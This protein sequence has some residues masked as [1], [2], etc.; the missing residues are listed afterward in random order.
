M[1]EKCVCHLNGYQLKDAVAR[2]MVENT[3]A[4]VALL[5]DRK[6]LFI[7]DSYATGTG[8]GFENVS[9]P[10]VVR[11]ILRLTEGVNYFRYAI[12]GAGFATTTSPYNFVNQAELACAAMDESTRA[13][14][15]DIVVGGGANDAHSTDDALYNGI[16]NFVSY[17]RSYFPNAKIHLFGLGWE[18]HSDFRTRLMNTYYVYERASNNGYAYHSLYPIL[19]NDEYISAD[20]CHP[21]DSGYYAL[22]MAVAN[23]LMGGY[24][25]KLLAPSGLNICG[26]YHNVYTDGV[27]V[28]INWKQGT[29]AHAAS[30]TGD[31]TRFSDAS[32]YQLLGCDIVG[33]FSFMKDVI[34]TMTDESVTYARVR[35]S[36]V[37]EGD[38][39]IGLYA[40]SISIV[41][42]AWT[43]YPNIAKISFAEETTVIP[44]WKA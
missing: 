17:C 32:C 35:L 16:A 26:V 20:G 25:E 43:N 9:W 36:F 33:E 6:F 31:F 3:A 28:Y 7:G 37:R 1:E 18:V 11:D 2:N 34:L 23:C 39:A 10:A 30:I 38:S 27:N 40:T 21:V 41:D 13:S 15:T 22:G 8:G 12:G 24:S 5:A 19:Q 29:V 4:R 42:G 14:I 44:I